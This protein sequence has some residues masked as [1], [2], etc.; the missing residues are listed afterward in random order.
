MSSLL[1]ATSGDLSGE[2][3]GV[4]PIPTP[5][6]VFLNVNEGE[7]IFAEAEISD[8]AYLII[9]G[10]VTL[11]KQVDG[12]EIELTTLQA[13][14]IFGEMG[15]IEDQI[16]SATAVASTEVVLEQLGRDSL[17]DRIK[18]D[19]TIALPIVQQLI[20]SLRETSEKFVHNQFLLIEQAGQVDDGS[21]AS[22]AK[23]GDTGYK[24]KLTQFFNID[25]DLEAF[26]PDVMVIEE[27][28]LPPVARFTL[29]TLLMLIFLAI[30]WAAV[31]EVD[32]AVS[33]TAE[34]KTSRQ[35]IVLQPMETAVIR[36]IDRASGDAVKTGD[37][38]A[39]LDPT[40]AQAD[41]L[42]AQQS[43]N[44]L[45]A[46]EAR[47]L[48]ELQGA[49]EVIFSTDPSINQV[50]TAL[51]Q[52][53]R[54][55]VKSQ[56][57][58]LDQRILSLESAVLSGRSEADGLAQRVAISSEISG[59][60]EKISATGDGSKLNALIARDQLL[61]A[62]LQQRRLAADLVTQQYELESSRS[63]RALF[64]QRS[65]TEIAEQLTA[66][67]MELEQSTQTVNKQQRRSS[68][69]EI[70]APADGIILE[71]SGFSV[72]SVVQ[73]A[74]PLFTIV[75]TN[76]DLEFDVY[77]A[78]GDIGVV[79]AGQEVKLML[80]TLPFQKHGALMGEITMIS[81]GTVAVDEQR[82]P[83]LGNAYRATVKIVRN[84]LREVPDAFR[85]LPGLEATAQIKAG[86][87]GVLTYLFYPVMRT[88]DNSFREK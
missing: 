50:E 8:Y 10:A 68:L 54:Q 14:A 2:Q 5:E 65:V 72:G 13:G 37:V 7:L 86:K 74:Q 15:L 30:V 17:L 48:A 11:S 49:D 58:A 36:Q 69:V 56:L 4:P 51:F 62:K 71:T 53:R 31:A 23:V 83:G 12:K 77:V 80:D 78:P 16:R 42:A 19:H 1:D 44:R 43:L 40:F 38:L 67:R 81:E 25:Q 9:S 55:A 27:R 87:R 21:P 75:P 28:S 46:R 41:L 57:Q 35:N 60:H 32:V 29:Y 76:V 70:V 45:Q 24:D 18:N 85:L 34:L 3:S 61:S 66:V 63:E 73:G 6:A 33:A 22:S 84:D 88:F 59:I 52:S 82:V 39:I 20:S 47:L 79:S 64:V 26:R